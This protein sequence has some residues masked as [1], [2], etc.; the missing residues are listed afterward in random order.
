MGIVEKQRVRVKFY[1]IIFRLL[2]EILQLTFG[3]V[4]EIMRK[5]IG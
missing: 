4:F 3:I 1:T 2:I 5:I